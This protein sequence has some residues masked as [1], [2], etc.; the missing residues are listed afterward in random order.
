VV[1][2]ALALRFA[3]RIAVR[4]RWQSLLVIALIAIPVTGL[5]SLLTLNASLTPSIDPGFSS[6]NPSEAIVAVLSV[7]GLM[8]F[9]VLCS[10]P[11]TVTA[12]RHRLLLAMIASQGRRRGLL[13]AIV[14]VYGMV[15]ALVGGVVG[16]LVGVAIAAVTIGTQSARFPEYSGVHID[17][18]GVLLCLTIA[19]VAGFFASAAPALGAS[20]IDVASAMRGRAQP[21]R[22]S[23]RLPVVGA[24]I[25][26]A[27]IGVL[28]LGGAISVA[29]AIGESQFTGGAVLLVIGSAASVIGVAVGGQTLLLWGAVPLR[30]LGSAAHLGSRD[31]SRNLSRSLPL[32]ATVISTAFIGSLAV[33]G[34]GALQAQ[35]VSTYEYPARS[36]QYRWG[37]TRRT[38]RVMTHWSP[39][40]PPFGM[41]WTRRSETLER[42]SFRPPTILPSH[43]P[44]APVPCPNPANTFPAHAGTRSIAILPIS[45][46]RA[47]GSVH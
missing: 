44:H 4:S 20:R 42:A 17:I 26:L 21:V 35:S 30:H 28:F 36:T 9:T 39:S 41:R 32:L 10:A 27:G 11:F 22:Q 15:L 18:R 40:V 46:T 14:C 3:L 23:A 1:S 47:E 8:E 38:T 16:S 37:S 34:M 12:S 2:V 5:V 13:F 29:S 19:A 31:S 6:G 43:P 45:P 24:I 25:T 33:A 7:F